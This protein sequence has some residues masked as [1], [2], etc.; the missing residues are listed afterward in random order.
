MTSFVNIKVWNDQYDYRTEENS[1]FDQ[2]PG[3]MADAGLGFTI[4]LRTFF[5]E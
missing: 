5:S 3:G 4:K 1:H 2:A